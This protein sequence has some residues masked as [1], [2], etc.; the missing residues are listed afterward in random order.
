M[1]LLDAGAGGLD[2]QVRAPGP[3]GPQAPGAPADRGLGPAETPGKLEQPATAILGIEGVGQADGDVL[4]RHPA[5]E[6]GRSLLLAG[7]PDP[8][9]AA[10]C[11]PASR[12]SPV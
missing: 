2:Q 9:G 4:T 1:G 11:W 12:N 6:H 7:D 3:G 5:A 10:A 8:A